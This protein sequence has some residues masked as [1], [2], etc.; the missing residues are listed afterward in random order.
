MAFEA[1]VKAKRQAAETARFIAHWLSD[2]QARDSLLKRAA[3]LDALA[4]SLQGP[5]V[6]SPSRDR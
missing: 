4:E 5:Q 6:P 3:D 1:E 2:H